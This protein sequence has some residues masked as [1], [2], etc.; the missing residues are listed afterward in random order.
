[1]P[2]RKSGVAATPLNPTVGPVRSATTGGGRAYLGQG[3][4]ELVDRDMPAALL[5]RRC[6]AAAGI[7]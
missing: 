1:M 2:V 7:T 5:G 3:A 4:E 6:K